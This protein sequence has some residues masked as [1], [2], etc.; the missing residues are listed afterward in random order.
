M[1]RPG[2]ISQRVDSIGMFQLFDHI[3]NPNEFLATCSDVL[4]PGGLILCFNHNIQAVSA[5]VLGERSPIIDIEHTFLYSPDTIRKLFE[6]NGFK[7][8]EVGSARN[9]VNVVSLLRL[10]PFPRNFKTR[11]LSLLEHRPRLG[12]I[13]LSLPLGNLYSI[14]QKV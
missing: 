7:V 14:A 6:K 9:F 10:I 3:A 13:N 12:Q 4:I 11:L 1:M 8:L 5:R 2:L